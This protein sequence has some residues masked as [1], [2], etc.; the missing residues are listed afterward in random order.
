MVVKGHTKLISGFERAHIPEFWILCAANHELDSVLDND[1]R[2][3]YR[4]T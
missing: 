3:T 4:R 1:G 2:H